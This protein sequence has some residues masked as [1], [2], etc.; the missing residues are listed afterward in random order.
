MIVF[1]RSNAP[2][3]NPLLL[4]TGVWLCV[5]SV[6]CLPPGWSRGGAGDVAWSSGRGW[7]ELPC[8][9]ACRAHC[10]LAGMRVA[11]PD[12]SAQ[13]GGHGVVT[14]NPRGLDS[15]MRMRRMGDMTTQTKNNP[16]SKTVQ[17]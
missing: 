11:G 3:F 1:A 12:G 6:P 15:H 7:A 2:V 10:P 9:C 13:G 8:P 14:I 5:R 16:P 4:M 17:P